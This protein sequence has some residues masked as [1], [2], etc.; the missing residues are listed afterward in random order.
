M[1]QLCVFLAVVIAGCSVRSATPP[2]QMQKA[3]IATID[4]APSQ[5]WPAKRFVTYQV[6]VGFQGFLGSIVAGAYGRLWFVADGQLDY[7]TQQGTITNVPT[8][9]P[10]NTLA[11]GWGGQIWFAGFNQFGRIALDGS[12][13]YFKLHSQRINELL[14]PGPDG[15]EWFATNGWLVGKISQAGVSTMYELPGQHHRIGQIVEGA[16]GHLW[17]GRYKDVDEMTTSGVLTQHP[18]PNNCFA[19]YSTVVDSAGNLWSNGQCNNQTMIERVTP[20]GSISLFP[21]PAG[22]VNL[23]SASG[24]YIWGTAHPHEVVRVDIKTGVESQPIVYPIRQGRPSDAGGIAADF[25]GNLW[26]TSFAGDDP[27]AA[28]VVEYH[29]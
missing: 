8:A 26:W 18:L 7:I 28:E 12:I 6:P 24:R 5:V 17:F 11:R 13:S 9:F 2:S 1:K 10:P 19:G 25:D 4:A 3:R 22:L 27:N 21:D 20:T 23:V 15:D 16:N 29:P 14:A